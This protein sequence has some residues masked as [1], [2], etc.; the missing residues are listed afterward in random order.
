[1]KKLQQTIKNNKIT[2][3]D[4]SENGYHL[5]KN[6]TQ[7]GFT[8]QTIATA[9]RKNKS[10]YKDWKITDSEDV[11]VEPY[12][13]SNTMN[14]IIAEIHNIKSFI[15]NNRDLDIDDISDAFQD[16]IKLDILNRI[17]KDI[18]SVKHFSLDMDRYGVGY[19]MNNKRMY[20]FGAIDNDVLLTIHS[21][22]HGGVSSQIRLDGN[23]PTTKILKETYFD[24][25]LKSIKLTFNGINML[26]DIRNKY[27][28]DVITD[29][30]DV[31][32]IVMPKATKMVVEYGTDSVCDVD[33][34]TYR[35]FDDYIPTD[36]EYEPVYIPTDE[37]YSTSDIDSIIEYNKWETGNNSITIEEGEV[38]MDKMDNMIP[39]T[40]ASDFKH[41]DDMEFAE[42]MVLYTEKCVTD[43]KTLDVVK[44]EVATKYNNEPTDDDLW[45]SNPG[46][47]PGLLIQVEQRYNELD[48]GSI[49]DSGENDDEWLSMVEARCVRGY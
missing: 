1:M 13:I 20:D 3:Y 16:T 8:R 17:Y 6:Y 35:E 7:C 38:E 45:M 41:H 18:N 42:L 25:S 10:K 9:F 49:G 21:T 44:S 30:Y 46:Y 48:D 14:G 47:L 40:S 2:L 22:I 19:Y 11:I 24:G 27:N 37:E 12:T 33:E 31:D 39:I 43:G 4:S 15:V 36:E 28:T 34:S 29:I 26:V 5:Y 23:L 32:G